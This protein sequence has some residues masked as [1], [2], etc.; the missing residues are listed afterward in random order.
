MPALMKQSLNKNVIATLLTPMSG[1]LH[2]I[3]MFL[4]EIIFPRAM[5]ANSSEALAREGLRRQLTDATVM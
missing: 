1:A 3:E 4:L 2:T 5:C